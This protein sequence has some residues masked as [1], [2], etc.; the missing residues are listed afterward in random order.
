MAGQLAGQWYLAAC[1]LGQDEDDAVRVLTHRLTFFF[2]R[3]CLASQQR[4]Y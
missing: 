3:I 4:W 2:L 1:D